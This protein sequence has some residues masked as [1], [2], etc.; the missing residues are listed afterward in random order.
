MPVASAKKT[1]DVFVSYSQSDRPLVTKFAED[2]RARKVSLWYDRWEMRPGDTLRERISD[3]IAQA[4]TFMVL[5]TPASLASDWVNYELN[6]GMLREIEGAQLRVVPVLAGGVDVKEIPVDLRT[7]YCLDI[8][9]RDGYAAALDQLVDLIHPARRERQE[10]L[11][12]LRAG[13]GQFR[14]VP[15]LREYALTGHDQTIQVAAL[16]GLAKKDTADATLVVIERMLNHWGVQALDAA[17]KIL[18]RRGRDGILGLAA[19]YFDD[20]R[21]FHEKLDLF[22][23][24]EPALAEVREQY[25]A[26]PFNWHLP[27]VAEALFQAPD[28]D[29]RMG[30]MISAHLHFGEGLGT[31]LPAPAQLGLAES[32][33]EVRIPGLLS[34]LERS[35]WRRSR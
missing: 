13:E 34:A 9:S 11:R 25:W 1:Y 22:A 8:S 16:R 21:Y 7:K 31:P 12:A 28:P 27:K 20:S 15:V 6:V 17:Y 3:G 23:E 24:I 29:I 33:A 30:A 35:M 10:L 19:T 32:Y 5:L 2:L 26:T 18:V 14:H 4:R